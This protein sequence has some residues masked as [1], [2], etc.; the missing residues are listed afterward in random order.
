VARNSGAAGGSGGA[1]GAGNGAAGGAP[2]RVGLASGG[3]GGV[4]GSSRDVDGTGAPRAAS[5][6]RSS[7]GVRSRASATLPV[8]PSLRPSTSVSMLCLSSRASLGFMSTTLVKACCPS[9]MSSRLSLCGVGLP[10]IP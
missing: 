7:S 3:A 9:V 1:G 8:S 6:W 2:S 5:I 4:G 10:H